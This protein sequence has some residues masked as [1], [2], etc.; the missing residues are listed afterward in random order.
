MDNTE[1]PTLIYDGHC[2]FCKIWIEYWKQLTGDR[3]EYAA[4]QEVG[5]QYPQIPAK[6]YSESVQL[7]RADGSVGSGARAV[8][9]TLG[10][11]K[12]YERAPVLAWISEA[13]YRFI[14]RHR[15]LFYWVTRLTFGT[16][17]EPTRF[18]A[19]QWIFLRAVAVIYAVAFGSLATQITGLIGSRGIL[20]LHDFMEVVQ[21]TLG[22]ARFFAMPTMFWW[23]SSDVALSSVCFAGI[24]FSILL[25]LGRLEKLMLVLLFVMYLSLSSAGQDFLSFQWDSLLLEAGFLA[26]FLGDAAIF[27]WLFRWLVFRLNFLSGSM[28]LLSH[29]PAWRNLTALDYHYHTQPLPNVISWYAD[30]LPRLFQH[31][32]TSAVL[33]IEIGIPFLIFLPR[34]LRMFGAACM[35]GLQVLILL[36]GNYAFFNWLTLVLCVFLFDDQALRRF[37]PRRVRERAVRRLGPV[38]RTFA[39]VLAGIVFLLGATRILEAYGSAPEP[40]MAAAKTF[41]PFQIVNSYGLFAVMTT[42]RPEIIVEGSNDGETWTPYEFRYKPGALDRGPRWIAP[43]QPRLDWQM[44]FAALGNYRQ[45]LWFVGFV[46]KLLQGSPEVNGLLEKNPF[47]DRPPRYIRAMVF[48]YTFTGW[49]SKD[50]WKREPLGTYL[51]PVGMKAAQ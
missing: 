24:A 12:A 30:K 23:N 20:P 27:P 6:A 28:K 15:D 2:G 17:I 36:T 26:I 18:A 22:P 48:E 50:W 39:G 7:V 14:A 44:W 13:M 32:A 16:K 9:E 37:A 31:I 35:I 42:T 33:G 41:A 3:I 43:F 5:G 21:K 47:P 51:P 10:L 40:L 46:A 19:T 49:G 4:S 8:F 1:V 45:N 29:D 38:A 34:R 11:E 25:F